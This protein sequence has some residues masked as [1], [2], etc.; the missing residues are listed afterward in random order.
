MVKDIIMYLVFIVT[1]ASMI[2]SGMKKRKER[3]SAF[4]IPGVFFGNFLVFVLVSYFLKTDIMRLLTPVVGLLISD[5][6]IVLYAKDKLLK[7]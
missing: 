5:L 1:A 7:R 2:Y 4:I 6:L 3:F